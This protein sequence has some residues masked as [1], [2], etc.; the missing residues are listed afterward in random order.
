MVGKKNDKKLYR[1]KRKERSEKRE[2]R[3]EKRR[4]N[5]KTCCDFSIIIFYWK[6]KRI[7]KKF[8]AFQ[9]LISTNIS[10]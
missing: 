6:I 8:F 10:Q 2:E 4:E 3:R 1:M 5:E 9:K 7:K